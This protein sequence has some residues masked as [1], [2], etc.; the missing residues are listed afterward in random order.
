MNHEH[1]A[2]A[3]DSLDF[4]RGDMQEQL[5]RANHCEGILL[6]HILEQLAKTRQLITQLYREG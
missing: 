1:Y 2:K 3:L 5:K 4:A 6:L